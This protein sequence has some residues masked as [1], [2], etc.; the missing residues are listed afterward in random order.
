MNEETREKTNEEEPSSAEI[1]PVMQLMAEM[2]SKPDIAE[3]LIKKMLAPQL[4]DLP[5]EAKEAL[6]KTRVE[7][8]RQPD[9]IEIVIDSGGDP[10]VEEVKA[11]LLDGMLVPL[12]Q[13]ITFFGCRV[14]VTPQ[15]GD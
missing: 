5:P 3:K 10:D 15:T 11:M 4:D 1:N 9:R 14:D 12:S 7:V 2:M 13:I 6:D 8:V